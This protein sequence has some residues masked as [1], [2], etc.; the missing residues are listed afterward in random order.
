[1]SARKQIEEKIDRKARMKIPYEPQKAR[2]VEER[3]ADFEPTF[4]PLTPEEAMQAAER[5]IHC[6]DP[7]ACVEACVVHNNIPEAMFHIEAGDFISA[8]EVYRETSSM[9][10]ICGR[11]CPHS[12]LC[13]GSCV[14]SK[15]GE[16]IL[17]GALE[18][19]VADYQRQHS[20]VRIPKGEP[21]G[22]RV[23][24][25]GS[26][27]SGL[28]CAEQLV[29]KGHEVTIFEALPTPGGLLIY[30]IPNF[31]LPK[32]VVHDVIQDL[33]DAGVEFKLNTRIGEKRTV[34]D[35]FEEGFDSIFLGVGTGIDAKMDVPGI[36]LPGIY[37]A[38]PF[39]IR[40]NVDPEFLPPGMQGKPEIGRRVAVIGGGDTAS[41]CL[42]S[43]LR[44]GAEEVTCLYRRTEAEMP[45]G[46][47]DRELAREEGAEFR[48]LTQPVKFIAGADGRVN[49]VE[50]LQCE[51]GEPD[52]SGRRRPIPIEGSNFT[53]EA[54]TVV[55]ALGYWPD[56]LVG[57]STPELETHNWG[58]IKIDPETG[59]TSRE[60]VFA[61]GDAVT[62]PDLV[63]TAMLAGRKAAESINE[64]L[65]GD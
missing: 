20:E 31:K 17:T 42:R 33:E 8:A 30:G 22:K 59:E 7:S 54:D 65:N 10:E 61:G 4:I 51:L 52:D 16:P 9:P 29:R 11:V 36:D 48:F 62:G 43:A 47:K 5:C 46:K 18:A 58:L 39:L 44:L 12:D 50:C 63:V 21:T 32:D 3:V 64:F 28:A 26:G 24:I 2:P 60:G 25:V 27:P 40:A 49:A 38:T 37:Q 55:L 57:E 34:D 19:F 6:P 1:M 15:R 35:L 13:Q 56:P 41:D 45:G 14:L 53:V 23:A